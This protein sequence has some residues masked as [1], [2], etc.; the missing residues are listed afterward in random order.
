MRVSIL[1]YGIGNLHSLSKAIA[2]AGGVPRVATNARD[3]TSTDVLV[4]PGVGAFAPAAQRLSA[5]RAVLREAILDGLPTLGV[6]LG[7]QLMFEESDE[8]PG[9]GL[10]V[11]GGRVTRLVANVV[12]AMGWNLL[13]DATDPLLGA[14]QLRHAYYAHSFVC[15]PEDSGTVTGW[16]EHEHDRFPAVIRRGRAVGVQFHPEKSSA[17][18][19]AFIRAFLEASS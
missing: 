7:M 13:L 9:A 12:P 17:P 8:G 3:A 4:L 19:I 1:D 2:A 14:S 18:G 16:T 10:A 15:R 5:D 6:C 11:F